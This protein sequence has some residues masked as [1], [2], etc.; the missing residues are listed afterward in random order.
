MPEGLKR[1]RV[2]GVVGRGGYGFAFRLILFIE[3]NVVVVVGSWSTF[4]Y[5]QRVPYKTK[6]TTLETTRTHLGGVRLNC[7]NR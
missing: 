4:S 5:R 6:T 2:K 3:T 1:M 7:N